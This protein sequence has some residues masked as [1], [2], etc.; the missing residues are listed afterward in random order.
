MPGRLL[1]VTE[2]S[3]MLGSVS[4]ASAGGNV[5]RYA[6]IRTL[7]AAVATLVTIGTLAAPPA[8]QAQDPATTP[9]VAVDSCA[10]LLT[11]RHMLA[12]KGVTKAACLR[13]DASG[14]AAGAGG[15]RTMGNPCTASADQFWT[16]NTRFVACRETSYTISI[17]SFP[18]G[19]LIGQ[20]FFWEVQNITGSTNN[21]T[22]THE[23]NLLSQGS[24]GD[25]AGAMIDGGIFGCVGECFPIAS[26]FPPVRIDRGANVAGF[27]QLAGDPGPGGITHGSSTVQWTYSQPGVF[28]FTADRGRGVPQIRCD[29]I[30]SPFGCVFPG[31]TPMFE[32]DGSD[33]RLTE[34]AR[35]VKQSQQSSGH[36][37][38]PDALTR[39]MSVEIHNA[40]RNIACPRGRINPPGK[41]CDEF[42]FA[43]TLEGASAL[44]GNGRTFQGC[45]FNGRLPIG[46]Q[47]PGWSACMINENHNSFGGTM[48][49]IFY[50]VQRILDGDRFY[51]LAFNV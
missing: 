46:V 23:Y 37:I 2:T 30:I 43:S 44:P 25:V 13:Q 48:T 39:T 10:E 12:S 24:W 34:F 16:V 38:Y 11:K 50:R 29:G 15:P 33:A 40:N 3:A 17:F 49:A 7:T 47:G 1:G 18:S 51:V 45:L 19:A 4:T 35:H 26:H 32:I 20:L 6:R 5:K 22:W 42:P 21:A 41:S 28:G 9:K 27:G 14:R 36:G 31:P 8:A